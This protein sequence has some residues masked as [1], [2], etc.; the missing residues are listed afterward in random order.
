MTL[1]PL[2]MYGHTAYTLI[3]GSAGASEQLRRWRGEGGGE[4]GLRK[5]GRERAAENVWKHG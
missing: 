4:C 2:E 5:E 1:L 3:K